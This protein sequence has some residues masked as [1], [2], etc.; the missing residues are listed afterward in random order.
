M[1][2]ALRPLC[3]DALTDR[4]ERFKVAC[5]CDLAMDLQV[6]G[7]IRLL[8]NWRVG[9]TCRRTDS[10]DDKQMRVHESVLM[11]LAAAFPRARPE[12]VRR[13][14]AP[15]RGPILLL[16]RRVPLLLCLIDPLTDRV[17]DARPV[18]LVAQKARQERLRRRQIMR[19]VGELLDETHLDEPFI[20]PL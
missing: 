1:Q 4:G 16:L 19:R 17:E 7:V 9:K 12:G 10:D 3:L 20:A 14:A 15:V 6:N 11:P 18:I 5:L 8:R 2:I 13:G